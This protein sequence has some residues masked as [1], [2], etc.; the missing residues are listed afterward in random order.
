MAPEEA[1]V[2]ADAGPAAMRR[3]TQA[4]FYNSIR[5]LFGE[6]VV[7]PDLAEPDVVASGLPSIGAS[8]ASYS[9]RGVE[10][11]HDEPGEQPQVH[12]IVLAAVEAMAKLVASLDAVP[13]GEGTLLDNSVLLGTTDVS[14]GRTHQ[15]D[16]FPIVLA[17]TAGGALKTGFHYRSAT[18][19]NTSHVQLSVLKAM[20]VPVGEF[21]VDAGRVTQ[22]FSVIES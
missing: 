7:V 14:Y 6:E 2:Q 17:G 22:G 11:T 21:G 1:Y 15:I 9:S 8:E 19:E 5:D 4:Q 20:D 10:L 13:E 3:L 18:K 12:S 16:E